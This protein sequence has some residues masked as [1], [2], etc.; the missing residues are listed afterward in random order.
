MTDSTTIRPM[1]AADKPAN[2]RILTHTPEFKPEEVTVAEELIDAHLKDGLKSGY[3]VLVAQAG[4]AIAGYVCYG[5]TP[6]TV[7]TWDIYWIAVDASL[8][9][10]GVGRALLKAAENDIRAAKG[11]L[12]IIE[13]SSTE[14][15]AKT[16]RFYDRQGYATACHIPDFYAPGDGKLILTKRL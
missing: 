2:M 10:K 3:H 13:T 15:Y 14:L 8:Q 12:V 4:R 16:Q 9:G 5:P 1:K 11:Y 6:M 7:S